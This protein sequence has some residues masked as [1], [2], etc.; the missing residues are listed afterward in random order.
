MSAVMQQVVVER[1]P[2]LQH[3]DNAAVAHALADKLRALHFSLRD[4][5][6]VGVLRVDGQPF[7]H[8]GR[9]AHG[10]GAV[11]GASGV[12]K[13]LSVGNIFRGILRRRETEPQLFDHGSSL[14]SSF[15]NTVRAANAF[16]SALYRG[17]SARQLSP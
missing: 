5:G 12:E 4:G 10:A 3:A 16:T 15:A 1:K 14:F 9:A 17:M 7:R 2:H 6:R 8:I 11:H 13:L